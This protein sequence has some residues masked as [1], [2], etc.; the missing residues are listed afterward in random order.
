MSHITLTRSY[1]EKLL[2][3]VVK[4]SFAFACQPI[5]VTR[6]KIIIVNNFD[7]FLITNDKTQEHFMEL[8]KIQ[9]NINIIIIII[10][11]I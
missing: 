8:S 2:Q 5:E 7:S 6:K 9:N 1:V 10:I 4:I 3:S 11:I